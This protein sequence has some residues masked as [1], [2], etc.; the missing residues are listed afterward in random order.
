MLK[1]K[2]NLYQLVFM[3]QN[4]MLVFEMFDDYAKSTYFASDISHP[5]MLN[6]R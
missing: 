5:W 1:T 2:N 6:M 4:L 3:D